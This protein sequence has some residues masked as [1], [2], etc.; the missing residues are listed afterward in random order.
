[1][2]YW[3]MA[4]RA[5]LGKVCVRCVCLA[6]L[7]IRM[8]VHICKKIGNDVTHA[9]THTHAHRIYTYMAVPTQKRPGPRRAKPLKKYFQRL[10]PRDLV[11]TSTL[12]CVCCISA[13]ACVRA[14]VK[15]RMCE[16]VAFKFAQST[17]AHTF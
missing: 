11:W 10:L 17:H 8:N 14:C 9:Y 4:R 2:A 6:R 15:V 1:M 12:V 13:C 5:M 16:R 7:S 3:K